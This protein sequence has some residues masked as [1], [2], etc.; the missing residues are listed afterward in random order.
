MELFKRN[1]GYQDIGRDS[2]L[3]ITATTIYIPI[4]LTQSFE[5]L[6]LYTDTKNP[7]FDVVTGFTGIWD[8]TSNTGTTQKPCLVLNN[9]G[10]GNP[11]IIKPSFYGASDASINV[12]NI[13]NCSQQYTFKWTGPNNYNNTTTLYPTGLKAGNY[14]LKITD[15][16]CDI[17]YHSFLI[18][19]AEILNTT[20]S[21]FNSQVNDINGTCNGS[22]SV[23]ASGGLA[24]YSYNWFINTGVTATTWTSLGLTTSTITGLCAG[25]YLVQTTDSTVP[26][27]TVSSIF[28]ITEPS[29]LSGN[30]IT[31]VNVDCSGGNT[32]QIEVIGL[33][34]VVGTGYTYT[35]SPGSIQNYTGLFKNLS[36]NVYSVLIKDYVGS[37][38]NLTPITITQPVAVNATVTL[39]SNAGCFGGDLGSISI[40][41][42]GGNAPYRVY[43]NQN[44]NL[45]NIY[46]TSTNII[47]T[48]LL[49]SNYT[50][51]VID[52]IGCTGST[53]TQTV[54]HREDFDITITKPSQING[55]D[56]PCYGNTTQITATTI[57]TTDTYTLPT[58]V[59]NIN[60]YA[61]GVYKSTCSHVLGSGCTSILTGLTAG[62]YTITSVS[63]VG[64]SATTFVTLTQPESVLSINLGLI[65]VSASDRQGVI[66]ING[67]VTPYTVLWGDSS[68]DITSNVHTTGYGV[69]SVT[70]TDN[71]GCTATDNIT[72]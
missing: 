71:N 49:A 64:C 13:T 36:Q 15:N 20:T 69:L 25:T 1:V 10:V 63:N 55:Y 17:S 14:T 66:N 61:N 6:G 9:C 39:L 45:F 41:P 31:T 37:T 21:L 30:V 27:V 7:I 32:G 11:T 40:T 60:F 68:N 4:F 35:L 44:N 12:N 58:P 59:G 24:P 29:V 53:L 34:G 18:P 8:T 52:R 62:D 3:T 48:D 5:D 56:I 23:V 54:Y 19:E 50:I 57:F 28:K 67:G 43:V 51:S 33:G 22:A 16:N 26:P 65:E 46:N 2:N 72:I 47:L 38:Y 42:F 70:V